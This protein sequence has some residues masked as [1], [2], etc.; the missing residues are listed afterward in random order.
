MSLKDLWMMITMHAS[1]NLAGWIIAIIVLASFIQIAPIKIN[2]WTWFWKAI[3]NALGISELRKEFEEHEAKSARTRILRFSDELEN[4]MWHSE[5]M[6]QQAIDDIDEYDKY[7]EKHPNFKNNRGKAAKAHIME[8]YQECLKEHK[9]TK[10]KK[11]EQGHM[12][13]HSKETYKP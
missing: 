5:D 12:E 10:E 11:D 2:P 4:K 1:D 8:V 3:Q 13:R 6:F 9:F 7:C